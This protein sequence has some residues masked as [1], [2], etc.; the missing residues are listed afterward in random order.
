MPRAQ[1]PADIV[2]GTIRMTKAA[3]TCSRQSAEYVHIRDIYGVV[4]IRLT[5]KYE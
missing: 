5:V 4:C 3:G 2:C 1:K